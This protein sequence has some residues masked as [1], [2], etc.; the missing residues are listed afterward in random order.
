MRKVVAGGA[1]G[2]DE[3]APP[4]AVGSGLGTLAP[5]PQR[6]SVQTHQCVG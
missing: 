2:E 1:C 5:P 3:A 4:S 6:R